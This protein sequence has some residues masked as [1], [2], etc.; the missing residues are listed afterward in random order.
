MTLVVPLYVTAKSTNGG[1]DSSFIG[2]SLLTRWSPK[3][4]QDYHYGWLDFPPNG[5]AEAMGF[6]LGSLYRIGYFG[7]PRWMPLDSQALYNTI[8]QNL[9][10]QTSQKNLFNTADGKL[11]MANLFSYSLSLPLIKASSKILRKSLLDDLNRYFNLKS[12]L[13]TRRVEVYKLIVVDMKKVLKLKSKGEKPYMDGFTSKGVGVTF[14]NTPLSYL[15]S[16]LSLQEGISSYYKQ[17]GLNGFAPA[18]ID[19]TNLDINID[20]E[21]SADNRDFSESVAEL[22]KHGLDLVKSEMEMT[23]IVISDK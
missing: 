21:F 22:N 3:M 8:N 1:I 10:L 23:C 2:R 15:T 5:T 16:H 11:N 17:I 9:I 7:L 12:E 13:A 6:D 14:L 19:E 4:P 20:L 18:I